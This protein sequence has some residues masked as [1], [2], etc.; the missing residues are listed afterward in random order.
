[1]RSGS[2][3]LYRTGSHA[4]ALYFTTLNRMRLHGTPKPPTACCDR[5]V[6]YCTVHLESHA[7]VRYTESPATVRYTQTPYRIACDRPVLYHQSRM[8]L[9][10]TPNPELHAI[11]Q[12]RTVPY[13]SNRMR[14]YGALRCTE[15][16]A[17]VRYTQTPK[18][19]RSGSIVLYRTPRIACDCRVHPNPELHAI[20][21]YRT[22]PCR[23]ACDY[24]MYSTM[25]EQAPAF[26]PSDYKIHF[27][28]YVTL[29]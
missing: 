12:Y 14:L 21:Q 13:T 20:G 9:Y 8:R 28:K 6:S 19:M 1:M 3:V 2:I 17:T 10:G 22:V 5:A 15:S 29:P 4:I 24:G 23:L 25:F 7:I 26:K 11:G 27:S 16:R 18:C